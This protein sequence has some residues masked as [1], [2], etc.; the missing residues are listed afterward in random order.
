MIVSLLQRELFRTSDFS[1][2]WFEFVGRPT[3][4][5]S[6]NAVGV[7]GAHEQLR[8]DDLGESALRVAVQLALDAGVVQLV[9]NESRPRRHR[10]SY[11]LPRLRSRPLS[12]PVSFHPGMQHWQHDLGRSDESRIADRAGDV[13]DRPLRGR[14]DV[15]SFVATA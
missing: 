5:Q 8:F 12:F 1:A 3:F 13:V 9:A 6:S 2:G 4:D 15:R 14:A 10:S 7:P 11:K